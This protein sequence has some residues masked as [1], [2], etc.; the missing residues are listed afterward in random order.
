MARIRID[1]SYVG[2]NYC[3][4]QIQPNGTSVQEVIQKALS[5]V[6]GYQVAVV[7]SGRTDAGVHALHQ[8]AH[9]DIKESTIEATKWCAILN[10]LL[11]KDIRI[12]ESK[13]VLPSFHARYSATKRSYCYL[14]LPKKNQNNYLAFCH[15]FCWATHKEHD[16]AALNE[17]AKIIVGQH[18]FLS[19]CSVRDC[20][21]S[22]IKTVTEAYFKQ[23]EPFIKFYISA[24]GFLWNMVRSIVGTFI[25]LEGQGAT[26]SDIAS[27]L[28]AKNRCEA[29]MT[30]PARGLFLE[31]VLY[32]KEEEVF[33]G[34]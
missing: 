12:L 30:A 10:A 2:T 16:I 15:P 24:N 29:G 17:Y 3:G 33:N 23:E 18:N 26:P 19:F 28:N 21:P 9:F 13:E 5:K 32:S 6:L 34:Q 22:K 20:S 27:I 14:I 25:E 31:N 11:P 4:W 7:G 8:V 1:L